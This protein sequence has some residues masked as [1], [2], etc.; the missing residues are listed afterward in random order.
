V[1]DRSQ[2]ELPLNL[3]S[4]SSSSDFLVLLDRLHIFSGL[5]K[6]S[7][8][9]QYLNLAENILLVFEPQSAYQE[10]PSVVVLSVLHEVELVVIVP[11]KNNRQ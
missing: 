7:N 9:K 8:T 1:S 6:I 10:A 2:D 11:L 5:T 3:F 4:S